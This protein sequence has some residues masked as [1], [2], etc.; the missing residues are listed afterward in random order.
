M[1]D[2]TGKRESM[3]NDN[4]LQDVE[5]DIE[6]LIAKI[7]E[8]LCMLARLEKLDEIRKIGELFGKSVARGS[9]LEDPV[10]ACYYVSS[11][12]LSW[13]RSLPRAY[14]RHSVEAMG[15]NGPSR[16]TRVETERYFA[17]VSAALR[18][19]MVAMEQSLFVST[20]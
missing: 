14:F 15:G 7:D 19:D 16:F 1:S 4:K 2:V 11:I 12:M 5:S 10:H 17:A 6:P 20:R 9:S 13:R 3:S 18:K 8:I